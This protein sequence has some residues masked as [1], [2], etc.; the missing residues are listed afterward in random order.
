M[1][2]CDVKTCVGCRTC[3]VTCSSFHSG[4]VSPVLARIRVAKLEEYGLDMAVACVSCLE[5]PCLECPTEAL[6]VGERGEILLEGP[7]CNACK[8]CVVAC[9][10]GAVGFAEDRPLICDLCGGEISCVKTCPSG[11][12]SYRADHRDL[13][14]RAFMLPKG[15]LSERRAR[16]VRVQ[17]E[18]IREGWKNGARV[19]S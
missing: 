13:S 14:L 10:I 9:P 1:I 5:K 8:T 15:S 11:A 7:L 19:D 2:S 18:P 16:Y 4:A 6:S 12:L 17:G 3:E